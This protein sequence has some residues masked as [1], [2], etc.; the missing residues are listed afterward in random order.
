M[1]TLFGV[2]VVI[3]I[4]ITAAYTTG[5]L[6]KIILRARQIYGKPLPILLTDTYAGLA[7][8]PPDWLRH[9]AYIVSLKPIERTFGVVFQSLRW[10]GAKPS[11]AQTPA[12]AAAALTAYLPEVAEA[13]RSLLWEYERALFSQKQNDLYI[14]RHAGKLIRRQALRTAFRQRMTA[15]RAE[16][17]RT[18]SRKPN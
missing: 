3:I 18:F 10:L 12:E 7:I 4:G 8:T 5:L 11:P 17:L 2:V 15:F 1:M 6:D 9:W 14:A 13:T 16:I